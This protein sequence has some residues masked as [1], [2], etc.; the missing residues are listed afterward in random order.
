MRETRA[1][2]QRSHLGDRREMHPTPQAGVPSVVPGARGAQR[3]ETVLLGEDT[4]EGF[5]GALPLS[6]L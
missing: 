3:R 6:S 2:A 1:Q 4:R 5:V